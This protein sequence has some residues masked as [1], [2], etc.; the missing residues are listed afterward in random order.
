L[1]NKFGK[2]VSK[3]EVSVNYSPKFLV[4]LKD[5]EVF[6]KKTAILEVQVDCFPAPVI[7]W[8][9]NEKIIEPFSPEY[10]NRYSVIDRKGGV[11]QLCIKNCKSEDSAIYKCYAINKLGEIN[12]Q[13]NLVIVSGPNFVKKFEQIDGVEKCDIKIKV[14]LKAHPKPSVSWYKGN[15]LLE[16]KGK[17]DFQEAN[18]GENT[19][20][21]LIIKS[22]SKTDEGQYQCVAINDAGRSQCVGKV[23][24]YPLTAP[25]FV[26]PLKEE[27]ILQ[28]NKLI[29]LIVKA[30]GIPVPKL[31]FRKDNI[32]I[33]SE[34]K[35]FI[36]KEN[37]DDGTYT[38]NGT[39]ISKDFYTGIYEA[40]AENPGGIARTVC[41]LLVKG[42]APYFLHKPEKIT[43]LEEMTAILGC[44]FKGDPVPT[45]TWSLKNKEIVNDNKF[46]IKYEAETNSSIVELSKCSLKD[47]GTYIVTIKNIHGTESAPVTLM[48][49]K[50]E[51][52]VQ[53]FKTFLKAVEIQEKGIEDEQPDWGQLKIGRPKE[54]DE[55]EEKERIKLKKVE[56]LPMFLKEPKSL[57]I[58]KEKEA[59][60]EATIKSSTKV[61]VLWFINGKEIVRK[62]GLKLE[63]D[64]NKN[65]FS[66]T[67][68]R[69]NNEHEGEITCKA[70]NEHG[71]IEKVVNL[72]IIG[73]Y[74]YFLI[75]IRA[76]KKVLKFLS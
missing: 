8:Y 41:N 45:V 34:N 68:K 46:R 64:V 6:E 58:L 40:I 4:N 25:K 42:F 17:Y 43:C 56:L 24:V 27:L 61:D 32:P 15:K 1:S 47:E 49:T 14:T 48:I 13:G 9:K 38:I 3:C 18:D 22:S 76:E 74:F 39:S 20:F 12:T 33:T 69:A 10:E 52:D 53:D 72:T 63:K 28:E 2:C 65:I 75:L 59:F 36:I 23:N 44:S 73:K 57:R 7:Q 19:N 35:D 55:E 16:D 67:I 51:D 62:E 70:I 31:L 54:K 60:F 30:S 37:E 29:E 21:T 66:L 71:F 11:Y 5:L 50:N 26:I